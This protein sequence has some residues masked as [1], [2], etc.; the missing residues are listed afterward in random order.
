MT[1]NASNYTEQGGEVTVIGGELRLLAGATITNAGTQASAVADLTEDSGA[2]GGTQNDDILDLAS[3]QAAVTENSGAIGG[4]N[5]GDLP[6]L[7]SPD[8]ATNAAAV[9]ECATAIN[10]LVTDATAL[11]DGVR[12]NAAKINAILAAL[13]GAG[14]IASS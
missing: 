9:R 2:I 14:L 8:A 10:G 7:S 12:E 6:D 1:Y 3:A 4:T 13:R 5:D 11:T